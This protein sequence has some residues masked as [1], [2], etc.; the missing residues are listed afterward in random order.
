MI[1]PNFDPLAELER[2]RK[3]SD[4]LSNQ[5]ERLHNLARHQG[6]VLENISNYLKMIAARLDTQQVQINAIMRRI[7]LIEEQ[8]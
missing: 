6:E 3:E 1:D 4:Y 2:I 7:Q 8:Q 5:F